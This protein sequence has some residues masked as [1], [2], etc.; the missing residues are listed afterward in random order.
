MTHAWSDIVVA[1]SPHVS[2]YFGFEH[3]FIIPVGN[4]AKKKICQ[5]SVTAVDISL[6]TTNMDLMM[7]L[8]SKS[9]TV[10]ALPK[11]VPIYLAYLEIFQWIIGKL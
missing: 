8:D 5:I 9:V 3:N 11:F 4:D 2:N 1:M 10:S 7:T 6:K